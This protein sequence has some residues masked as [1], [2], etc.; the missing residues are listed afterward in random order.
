[1]GIR[2]AVLRPRQ[3]A[4][5][6]FFYA[7]SGPP[8]GEPETSGAGIP[9]GVGR[10]LCPVGGG[11]FGGHPRAHRR[12][13]VGPHL[14]AEAF[15]SPPGCSGRSSHGHRRRIGGFRGSQ[16]NTGQCTP[17]T[18]HPG[19]IH[20]LPRTQCEKGGG[21]GWGPAVHGPHVGFKFPKAPGPALSMARD[22]GV[23]PGST[24]NTPVVR[25]CWHPHG[26]KHRHPA[27]PEP[28]GRGRER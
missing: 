16:F 6:L 11:V 21:K 18:D 19:V 8:G 22:R 3:G 26:C 15:C 4:D 24:E 13:G 7:S 17:R 25:G 5:L 28:N 27:P 2:A 9:S 20:R 10:F 23:F 14:P 12:I 1:M